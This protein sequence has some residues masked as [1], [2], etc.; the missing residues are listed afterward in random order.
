MDIYDRCWAALK[1]HVGKNHP[2]TSAEL[3]VVLGTGD[4]HRGTAETRAII[5][6]LLRR[7]LPIGA[8]AEGY[9]LLQTP[10]EKELYIREL[11][12]RAQGVLFRAQLVERAFATYYAGEEHRQVTHWSPEPEEREA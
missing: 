10:E 9:F 7:G 3:A 6:E 2:M 1:T 4:E 5:T 8:T 12:D 11:Q